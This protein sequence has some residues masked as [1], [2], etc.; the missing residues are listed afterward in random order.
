MFTAHRPET[1]QKT[2]AV[3]SYR[4]IVVPLLVEGDAIAA[5]ETGCELADEHRSRIFGVAVLEI[6]RVLPLDAHMFAEEERARETLEAARAIADE[7]GVDFHARVVRTHLA[8]QAVVQE[9]ERA[10]ADLIVVPAARRLLRA[11]GAIFDETV[12]AILAQAPCRVV[13]LTPADAHRSVA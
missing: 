2:T 4:R 10:E 7:R 9:A 13:V 8:G 1:D 11:H 6:P 5:I 3:L 12:R